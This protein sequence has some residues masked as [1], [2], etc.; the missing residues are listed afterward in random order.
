LI[1]RE[2]GVEDDSGGSLRGRRGQGRQ[3]RHTLREAASRSTVAAHSEGGG[4]K[5]DSGSATMT[6]SL[7]NRTAAARLEVGVEAASCSGARDEAAACSGA[8][9]ED[10]R[11][12]QWHG[13][14]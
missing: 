5:V 1:P 2:V 8:R 6:E 7:R 3:W 10:G 14:F 9:I 12:R 11:W 4:V 13:G